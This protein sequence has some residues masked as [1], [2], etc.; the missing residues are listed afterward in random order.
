MWSAFRDRIMNKST[1]LIC[2]LILSIENHFFFLQ[3]TP[4]LTNCDTE[5]S[6]QHHL[7]IRMKAYINIYF[8][9][10]ARPAF[11]ESSACVGVWYSCPLFEYFEI[12]PQRHQVSNT[13]YFEI[14]PQSHQ[15]SNTLSANSLKLLRSRKQAGA[16]VKVFHQLQIFINFFLLKVNSQTSIFFFACK[17]TFI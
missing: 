6:W 1:E 4:P 16:A 8:F 10:A 2:G 17:R 13:L 12:T 7:S 14:T 5:I 9:T 11:C 15:V 3:C